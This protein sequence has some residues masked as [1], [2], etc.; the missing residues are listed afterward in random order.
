[1]TGLIRQ[2]VVPNPDIFGTYVK[3]GSK[4]YAFFFPERLMPI[5]VYKSVVTTETASG[6][7]EKMSMVYNQNRD[8]L[9]KARARYEKLLGEVKDKFV[10]SLPN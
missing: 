10:R 1:L 3:H 5:E 7:A 2:V 6:F 9:S 8:D 4:S